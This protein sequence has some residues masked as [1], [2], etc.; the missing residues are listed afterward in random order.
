MRGKQKKNVYGVLLCGLLLVTLCT[1]CGDNQK[2]RENEAHALR[3]TIGYSYLVDEASPQNELLFQNEEKS[4]IYR[5]SYYPDSTAQEESAGFEDRVQYTEKEKTTWEE[6]MWKYNAFCYENEYPLSYD[7]IIFHSVDW[8]VELWKYVTEDAQK[9][10]VT[11]MLFFDR[12]DGCYSIEMTYPVK[13]MDAKM[14]LYD[15]ASQQAFQVD[16]DHIKKIN[17]G[18]AW[19]E[20]INEEGDL[21]VT[22]TNNG[23]ET[24]ERVSCNISLETIPKTLE[25]GTVQSG[26]GFEMN[27]D[28]LLPGESTTF[29]LE[30]ENM[31]DMTDYSVSVCVFYASC[32]W[33]LD[34][35]V[36]TLH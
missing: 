17:K 14:M 15:I 27:K 28:D 5:V 6:A 22:V 3:E 20:E 8:D 21:V 11:E 30:A 13:N 2:K 1:G 23:D 36:W 7:W 24:A 29:T 33:E 16:T 12:A 35:K 18:I 25:D 10:S 31:E 4:I 32:E 9:K 26:A 19:E 34:G